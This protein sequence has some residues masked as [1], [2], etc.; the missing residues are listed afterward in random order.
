MPSAIDRTQL[1]RLLAYARP[2]WP[3]ALGA[4]VASCVAAAAAAAYAY[5]IGPLLQA[6]LTGGRAQ[7][8]GVE[9]GGRDLFWKVP[10]AVVA[11]A[12]VKALAQFL[13]NGWMTAVGQ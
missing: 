3:L 5:L 13:Q 6:V 11:V 12:V 1:R 2:H 10:A 7:A 8:L 4:I 9:V